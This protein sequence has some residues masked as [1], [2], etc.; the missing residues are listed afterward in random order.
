MD[1]G[2]VRRVKRSLMRLIAFLLT[3]LC[4]FGSIAVQA[5]ETQAD[6]ESDEIVIESVQAVVP[7]LTAYIRGDRQIGVSD[8]SA[9]LDSEAL[10]VKSV[11]FFENMGQG[12]TYYILL[13]VSAS[14]S[15]SYFNAL[16]NSLV[17]FRNGLS[18]K[19]RMV[20]I[21]FGSSVETVLNGDETAEEAQEKIMSLVNGD[22]DTYFYEA[23]MQAAEE[24]DRNNDNSREVIMMIS[25][26]GDDHNA[27]KANAQEAIAALNKRNIPVYGYAAG[28]NQ[29]NM[30][31]FAELA[32]TCGG[33]VTEFT[34]QETDKI[35]TNF[36]RMLGEM[37]VVTLTTDNNIASNKTET[38]QLTVLSDG[39]TA[40]RSVLITEH[41][42][43]ET[44]P[45][46]IA[47]RKSGDKELIISF[48]EQ[49]SGADKATAYVVTCDGI[50]LDVMGAEYDASDC[51]AAISFNNDL[52]SGEYVIAV[53]GIADISAEANPVVESFNKVIKNEA[54]GE[55]A[56]TESGTTTEAE[57]AGQ[58]G[59]DNE[60]D[61]EGSSS[62]TVFIIVAAAVLI[63]IAAGVVS[64]V[65]IKKK[66]AE[67]ERIKRQQEEE[68]LRQSSQKAS[69]D[70]R[71]QEPKQNKM[72]Q[73]QLDAGRRIVFE[74]LNV[75]AG[76]NSVVEAELNKSMIVGRADI[77][78]VC[79]KDK[80]ISRQHFA[81]EEKN[82]V[83]Y[84]RD[85]QTT[86]G[87]SVN[88]VRLSGVKQLNNN[89]IIS[90]GSVKLRV[91][92]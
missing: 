60:A 71:V 79:I 57:T 50:T 9:E 91:R 65:L 64:A 51:S 41:I 69:R 83:I 92:W 15:N 10:T 43:D 49:V 47:V 33:T 17:T 37:Q 45:E 54:D 25:D 40:S 70:E 61:G 8:I 3:F 39:S 75:E 87:T 53:R 7:E 82:G 13:D 80:R 89:D 42:P 76:Q 26:G 44:A 35:F 59:E 88:G 62:Y 56:E 72:V 73:L 29:N 68:R 55:N 4:V 34:S 20:L 16:Q 84:V 31:S 66:K 6:N 86:N 27:G 52:S 85:L 63:L 11:D 22:N 21:T 2:L 74:I 58:S 48:S 32:E 5:D 78:D 36:K 38:L 23:L 28:A 18:D 81:L 77:C 67:Q 30:L 46:I 90:A 1:R 19:D 12:V 24:T 14:F